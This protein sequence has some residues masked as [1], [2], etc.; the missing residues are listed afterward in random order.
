MTT[1]GHGDGL[2]ATE[3][4]TP[5]VGEA[6]SNPGPAA[7]QEGPSQSLRDRLENDGWRQGAV[8]PAAPAIVQELHILPFAEFDQLPERYWLL[9]ASQDCDVVCDRLNVEP[10]VEVLI[11]EPI[12]RMRTAYRNG[13]DPRELHLMLSGRAGEGQAVRVHVRNRAMFRRALL[14]DHFPAPDCS[15]AA[16]Y[17]EQISGLLGG[18]YSRIAYP[19]AF[20]ARTRRARQ[21]LASVLDQ[22][23]EQVIDIYFTLMPA[24]E[25]LPES[26]PY[27][28]WVYAVVID[29][30]VLGDPRVYNELKK[31]LAAALRGP[32]RRCPGVLL[33]KVTVCG[34]DDI[35]LREF[36][37]MMPANL[38]E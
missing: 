7:A 25:E 19:T 13:R 5:K 4:A 2:G 31:T 11:A 14:A 36:A 10:A 17:I 37:G 38:A 1:H 23:A 9:I 26:E 29:E 35:T 30:I 3:V 32:L 22:Y 6:V 33:E 15:I 8:V 18:R 12:E 16:E 27:R 20:D 24:G 28:L 34:R 21:K